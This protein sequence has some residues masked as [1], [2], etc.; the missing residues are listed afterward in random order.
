[1]GDLLKIKDQIDVKEYLNDDKLGLNIVLPGDIIKKEK[2]FMNGHGTY[3]ENGIIYSSVI[4]TVIQ[5]NKLLSVSPLKSYYTPQVGDIVVGRVMEIGDKKW[6]IEI[7]S[8]QYAS[9]HLN[10]TYI[11]EQRIKTDED[12]LNMR[13]IM[14]E[15]DLACAEVHSINKDKT[16]NLHTRSLKYGK[17]ENGFLV[18]V[19]NKLVKT[20]TNHFKK[21]QCGINI[22]FSHNGKI[23]LNNISREGIIKEQKE[24]EKKQ[25]S[26]EERQALS[27]IS[28]LLKLLDQQNIKISTDLLD[29]LY[30]FVITN[31]IES[32]NILTQAGSKELKQYLKQKLEVQIPKEINKLMKQGDY[33][34]QDY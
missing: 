8:N 17:L 14:K 25:Y 18:E 23:W 33:L 11:P 32:S 3:E 15:G 9:L 2:G 6:K 26:F 21:L 29:E 34:A 27:I 16:A 20:Q 12:E 5:T 4:G 1:M 10:S 7:G 24:V 30:N 13:Q 31:K 19:F 28:N 22:I